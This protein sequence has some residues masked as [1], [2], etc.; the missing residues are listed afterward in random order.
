MNSL[1]ATE[2]IMREPYAI[3]YRHRIEVLREIALRL[4]ELSVLSP[5]QA[6][7]TVLCQVNIFSN[8][9][10]YSTL[11]F[12]TTARMPVRGSK[13]LDRKRKAAIA[14]EVKVSE[15]IGVH[16]CGKWRQ[17]WLCFVKDLRQLSSCYARRICKISRKYS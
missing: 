8:N 10:L 2:W 4:R 12:L 14:L 7:A 15:D 9:L 3:L 6:N 11:E 13:Y 5:F 16:C 17:D 1:R